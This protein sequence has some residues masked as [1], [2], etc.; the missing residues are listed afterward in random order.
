MSDPA[1]SVIIASYN[2]RDVVLQTLDRLRART[3]RMTDVEVIVVDNN[4]TD[5]TCNALR[6][7]G[8]VNVIALAENLGSCAKAI[9][10]DAAR[11]PILLFLD[12]DS[13]PRPGCIESMLE[14]FER[15]PDLAAA[16]F[17]VH[18]P[19]GSQ[20]CSAL[21]H[22]FVG[23]G[24]GLRA[25]AAREVGGLDRSFFMQAEEYDLAFRLLAAGWGVEVFSALQA[26]HLKT[27][28]A[29]RVA[30]TTYYD[31]RNNLRVVARYLPDEYAAVYREDWLLRYRWLAERLDRAAR[32]DHAGPSVG[33]DADDHL[34]AYERGA[35]DGRQLAEIER[36]QFR[37]RRL[38]AAQLEAVF[39]WNEIEIRLLRLAEEG[40]RRVAL[41]DFGKNV[42]AFVH[43]TRRAGLQIAAIADDT[44][45]APGRTYR[46]VPIVPSAEALG[47]CPDAIVISNTSY[48]HAQRRVESLFGKTTLPICAW[49]CLLAPL[50]AGNL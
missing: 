20:E 21:P 25:A 3:N 9:G 43:G 5:G 1:L 17:T 11:A 22:V 2:R 29:R 14:L 23:C 35:A 30:R 27:P 16:G 31:V 12:D 7:R 38:A 46:G 8:D 48:V 10:V 50:E 19:D 45:A 13:Y 15:Q 34:A 39:Q 36:P 37:N 18:L 44:W 26:D 49:H 40:V 47:G 6:A 33:D 28:H 41:A 24:V 4:S 42:Y 32:T